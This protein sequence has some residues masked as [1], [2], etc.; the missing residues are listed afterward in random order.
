MALIVKC[1]ACRARM[2]QDAT[3][4]PACGHVS[5]K[6]VVDY[7]PD[8]RS[9]KRV[10]FTLPDKV[11]DIRDA[12][13]IEQD[14]R[15]AARSDRRPPQPDT[16]TTFNE[17]SED[18]LRWVSVHKSRATARERE[19]TL[20]HILGRIGTVP[21]SQFGSRH[22]SQYQ[23]TRMKDGVSNKTI[24]KELYYISASCAGAATRTRSPAASPGTA[25]RRNGRS[26]S[27]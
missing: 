19:Y 11:T 20:K 27:C 3:S 13:R 25:C 17:L 16:G 5:R 22:V 7:R 4:C 26:R 21:V 9:G 2:P 1:R 12:L 8:G 18:Y 24:N 15:A 10:F 14:L 23:M 6:Y